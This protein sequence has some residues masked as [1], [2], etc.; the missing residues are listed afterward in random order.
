MARFYGKIG[1]GEAVKTA[2]GVTK[3]VITELKYFGDVL[4]DSIRS[5]NGQ[6]INPDIT[7]GNSLSIVSN[8]Y[9]LEHIN[10]MRYV[11]WR[12]RNW[13][14]DSVEEQYPRLILRMGG[15]YTGPTPPTPGPA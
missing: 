5:E 3:D 15:I 9:A 12:G 13:K 4:R 11:N 7:L 6:T 1:F 2:P 14:I 8:K 10:D